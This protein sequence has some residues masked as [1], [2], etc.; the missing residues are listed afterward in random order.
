MRADGGRNFATGSSRRTSLR[1]TISARIDAVNVFVIDPISNTLPVST[2]IAT[3]RRPPV[4]S[5]R[6]MTIPSPCLPVSG[7]AWTRA[8]S[9]ALTAESEGRGRG[10]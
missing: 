10:C 9:S 4:A 6:P 2:P 3:Y 1:A 8:A 7:K 5:S